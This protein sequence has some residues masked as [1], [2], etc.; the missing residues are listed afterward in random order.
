[1]AGLVLLLALAGVLGASA[2]A[3]LLG[4][5]GRAI[6]RWIEARTPRAQGQL[7]A[8]LAE[9]ESRVGRV[10]RMLREATPGR[11]RRWPRAGSD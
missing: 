8:D 4:P 1:M 2:W 5:I 3:L 9:L 11:P 7:M 10:E 6:G